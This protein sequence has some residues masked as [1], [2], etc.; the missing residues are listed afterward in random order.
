HLGGARAQ[1]GLESVSCGVSSLGV[2]YGRLGVDG[3]VGKPGTLHS[4]SPPGDPLLYPLQPSILHLHNPIITLCPRGHLGQ[5]FCKCRGLRLSQAQGG[6]RMGD[7][8][9]EG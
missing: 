8:E 3:G 7:G 5:A 9:G 6:G 2:P 4:S 1:R